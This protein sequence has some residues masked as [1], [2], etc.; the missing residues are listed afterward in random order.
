MTQL[1]DLLQ[2]SQSSLSSL[3]KNISSVVLGKDEVIDLVLT[4]LV[5][6]GHLLIED[7]PGVGKTTLA[8]AVAI[9]LGCSFK[10]IQFTADMLPSDLLGVSI[11]NQKTQ[12]FEF[13]QGPLFSQFVLADEINR[14]SPRTQSALLQAMNEGEITVDRE[15]YPLEKPFLVFATQNP[16]ESYGTYPLPESQLDRFLM[17]IE[18]GYPPEEVEKEILRTRKQRRPIEDLQSVSNPELLLE[19]Q[20]AVDQVEFDEELQGYLYDLVK[21][22][23]HSSLLSIG[24]STRGAI[25]FHR[26]VRAYAMVQS[27]SYVLPDDIKNLAAPCLAHRISLRQSG[28]GGWSTSGYAEAEQIILDLLTHIPVPL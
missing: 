16:I 14:T 2:K 13:R 15:T 26:A 19:L 25:Q 18:I 27:R 4:T 21:A 23:R 17:R 10:R 24:V 5:T 20:S 12:S 9:S 6:G 22:T 3:K 7:V 11:F 8:N 28:T 1:D